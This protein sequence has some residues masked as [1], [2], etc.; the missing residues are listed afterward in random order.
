MGELFGFFRVPTL[1][2]HSSADLESR[3]KFWPKFSTR[4]TPDSFPDLFFEICAVLSR[5][6]WGCWIF[7]WRC[8]VADKNF[9]RVRCLVCVCVCV[10][11]CVCCVCACACVH[12]STHARTHTPNTQTN[13]NNK[14]SVLTTNNQV[15]LLCVCVCVANIEKHAIHTHDVIARACTRVATRVHW[16][17]VLATRHG[18]YVDV[19]VRVC[20]RDSRRRQFTGTRISSRFVSCVC[21]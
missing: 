20:V 1:P 17:L 10:C 6:G 3:H 18:V 11:W 14:L 12:N 15:M 7:F 4:Y 16:C 19:C 21:A 9:G 5:G 2:P 13:K 8:A